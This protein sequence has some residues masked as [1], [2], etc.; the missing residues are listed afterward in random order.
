MYAQVPLPVVLVRIGKQLLW[1][2][3]VALAMRGSAALA[4]DTL[5]VT[6]KTEAGEALPE[7]LVR[8][9]PTLGVRNPPGAPT[10]S[11]GIAR[12]APLPR[13]SV[14]IDVLRIGYQASRFTVKVPSGPLTVVLKA[15]PIQLTNVCLTYAQ[16]AIF[17]VIDSAISSGTASLTARVRDGSF[18]EVQHHE[19]PSQL[20]TMA[21]AYE[22]VGTYDIEVTARGYERWTRSNV[23]IVKDQYDC[24]VV[25]QAFRVRLTKR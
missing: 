24:H 22:R 4:Q 23:R 19:L 21:F 15:S 6:V 14:A 20:T 8:I 13:D 25:Q 10:D 12:L 7:A 11:A 5:V 18:E 2:A 1:C 9:R 17:L 16:P 3:M